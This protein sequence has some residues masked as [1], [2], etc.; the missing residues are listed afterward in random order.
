[1]KE[2]TQ[3]TNAYKLVWEYENALH[4]FETQVLKHIN[5]YKK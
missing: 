5:E 4:E 1:M 3:R 2:K